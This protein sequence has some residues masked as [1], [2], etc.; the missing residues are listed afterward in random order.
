MPVPVAELSKVTY[1]YP[2]RGGEAVL[3]DVDLTIHRDDFLGMIGPNGSGKTT[4]L[5]ILMGVLK[6]TSGTVRVFGKRPREV[7]RRI[8][9]VPQR[10]EIDAGVPVSVLEVVLTGRLGHSSW[11]MSYGKSHV[12]AARDAMAQVGVEEFERRQIGEL[13]GGQRQRVLIARAIAADVEMLLLDEPMAGVDVH[14]ERGILKTLRALKSRMPIVLVS[15]DIGSVSHEVNRVACVNRR[16]A[17]HRPD[18]VNDDVIA[19]MY[20]THG[21]VRPVHHHDHCPITGQPPGTGAEEEE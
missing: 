17:V 13:S 16:L 15:H 8:G 19:E 4:L 3:E 6:P 14:M 12:A 20:H 5:R 21:V 10:A 7:S 18:E 2:D 1:H 9:Y 11:G